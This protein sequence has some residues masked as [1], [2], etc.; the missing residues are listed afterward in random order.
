ME[1]LLT[2]PT[3]TTSC[4]HY[5]GLPSTEAVHDTEVLVDSRRS[6]IQTTR[7]AW[8]GNTTNHRHH[9]N[10]S[11][12]KHRVTPSA[13][14]TS[15]LL[16]STT[17][18]SSLC[19]FCK[20][21][22]EKS[23]ASTALARRSG[24]MTRNFKDIRQWASEGCWVCQC[25]V[26]ATRLWEDDFPG[27]AEKFHQ[28][29]I[30]FDTERFTVRGQANLPV[31]QIY[32]PIGE[33]RIHRLIVPDKELPP[34]ASSPMTHNFIQCQINNCIQSHEECR[35]HP[36]QMSQGRIISWPS[37][38]LEIENTTSLVR[39]V[40]FEPEMA[41]HYAAVSYCWGLKHPH[42]KAEASTLN[43]LR[44][45]ISWYDL[46][47]TLS[48]AVVLAARIG[49]RW[50][51]I[52]SMCIIQDNEQDW[53]MEA[54]KMST[55]YQH[56]LVTIIANSASCC[57]EG[58]LENPRKPSV[59]LGQVS[60]GHGKSVE[61]RGRVLYDWGYHRGGPQSHQSHYTKW[62]DPV[63]YRG[64]TL[65]E[66]IL[67]TRS[68]CFTSGE[69]Q[70]SCQK[71]KACECGKQLFGKLYN[72][73]DPKELWFKTVEE[74]ACRS[75]TKQSDI[76]VAF[77]GIQHMTAA[78]L[79]GR[80]LPRKELVVGTFKHSYPHQL[81]HAKYPSR[82]LSMDAEDMK[83][84]EMDGTSIRFFGPLYPAMF[85]IPEPAKPKY[86]FVINE[87][88]KLLGDG[89]PRGGPSVVSCYID[90]P[91][92]RTA[93]LDEDES[94]FTLTRAQHNNLEKS[95]TARYSTK[96]EETPV[97]VLLVVIDNEEERDGSG[98]LLA[99][100][101]KSPDE[102]QRLGVVTLSNYRLQFPRAPMREVR[103]S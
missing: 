102:Y 64:W 59:K 81:Q 15:V 78:K 29:F 51:W 35:E 34:T 77:K 27:E 63:D 11:S 99:R 49:C 13:E 14:R 3:L 73:T 4:F 70:F 72:T 83:G 88:V 36:S 23:E 90:G 84:K 39:L 21:D 76:T 18:P 65:Q 61:L 17:L 97:F 46:P 5:V 8:K 68:L 25:V 71:S 33:P 24:A 31:I 86:N 41:Q 60:T 62:R 16:G 10:P 47:K 52:D 94:G 56:A 22:E 1:E 92:E 12:T 85:S 2:S 95:Q 67:S 26:T 89:G 55:V 50:I 100:S 75:L 54:A 91:L 19:A 96:I 38:V 30:R 53:A 42:L 69:V 7:R 103:I 93:I 58:F 40:Q 43:S 45:G 80:M 37:R 32:T 20:N 6:T 74:Y 87:K 9:R 101:A 66:S 48:D 28:L 82:C 79:R 44:E 57:N 98:L